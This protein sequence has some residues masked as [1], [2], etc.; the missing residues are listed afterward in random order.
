V[1]GEQVA[2][3][4]DFEFEESGP[5]M[6]G[7][8][9]M[10]EPESIEAASGTSGETM[11]EN[12]EEDKFSGAEDFFFSSESEEEDILGEENESDPPPLAEKTTQPNLEDFDKEFELIFETEESE[13]TGEKTA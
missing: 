12:P 9:L 10:L 4:L 5:E 6:E 11:S 1:D 13:N 7:Y 2:D 3:A 8:E